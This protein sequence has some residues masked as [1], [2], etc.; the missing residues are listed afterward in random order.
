ML[1]LQMQQLTRQQQQQKQ[2][3][4]ISAALS[5]GGGESSST[6]SAGIK[7]CMAREAFIRLME[8][9]PK[10]SSVVMAN[11]AH[12]LGIELSSVG[13]GLMRDYIEKRCP[14]GDNRRLTQQAYLWAFAWETGFRSNNIELMAI[15]S[16]GLVYIDQTAMDFNKTKLS[17]LLTALPEP[18]Y[19]ICQKNRLPN[20]LS[21][22]S[23]LANASWVGA[24]VAFMKDLDFL[25]S[26]MKATSGTMKGVEAQEDGREEA[27]PKKPWRPKKKEGQCWRDHRSVDCLDGAKCAPSPSPL[28]PSLPGCSTS[29]RGVCSP[30]VFSGRE[31]AGA[32]SGG[33]FN[34]VQKEDRQFGYEPRDGS[35]TASEHEAFSGIHHPGGQFP[36]PIRCTEV[37]T[38]I[39]TAAGS[40]SDLA[41]FLHRSC[42]PVRNAWALQPQGD[43]WPCPLRGDGR[44]TL[45][46]LQIPKEGDGFATSK[47]E[48]SA[49]RG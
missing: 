43:L 14:L 3:G 47:L 44:P 5:G 23:R 12:E 35:C 2:Q 30:T 31:A 19:S 49:S 21:P 8:D 33:V 40:G 11:A 10:F 38:A 9:L 6:A 1:L 4:P 20:T 32:A 46:F 27:A 37:V 13:P 45:Q 39:A 28:V 48:L 18:Q 22:F 29:G 36:V 24:N 26:K 15:A 42:H 17:W 7:G 41:H 34:G 25:E 16:R